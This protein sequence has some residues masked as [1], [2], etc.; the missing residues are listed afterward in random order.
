MRSYVKFRSFFRKIAS[1][2]WRD[3]FELLPASVCLLWARVILRAVPFP[4]ALRWAEAR[5][6]HPARTGVSLDRHA[7]RR[8]RAVERVGHRLFPRNPCLTE[9][10]VAHR[11]L[12]RKGYSSVLRIGV[13]KASQS[14]LEAHAWVEYQGVVVIGARGLSEKHVPLPPFPAPQLAA[15]VPKATDSNAS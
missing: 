11:L 9:A 5:L 8:I 4:R 13:R 1:L 10:L 3:R 12:C 15:K 7:E 2:E 14:A 6:V